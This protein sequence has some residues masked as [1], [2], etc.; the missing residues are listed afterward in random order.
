MVRGG[1]SSSRGWSLSCR[2][3][4]FLAV[5]LFCQVAYQLLFRF[6]A[7]GTLVTTGLDSRRQDSRRHAVLV[8]QQVP[9]EAPAAAL[10]TSLTAAALGRAASL[11]ATAA[12]DGSYPQIIHHMH[13]DRGSLDG[14]Q[15]A[16]VATCVDLHAAAGWQILF[17]DDDSLYAFVRDK[18]AWY[19]EDWVKMG[20]RG[21]AVCWHPPCHDIIKKIDASR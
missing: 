21:L 17:W 9:A 19:Y 12:L 20:E 8:S 6:R 3:Y 11:A 1:C 4:L 13:K 18:Y 10:P 15:R 14:R 16:Y 7:R 5:V 2:V